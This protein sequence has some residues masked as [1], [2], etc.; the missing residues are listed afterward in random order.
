M[1][2]CKSSVFSSRDS[3]ARSEGLF[4]RPISRHS[5]L[6]SGPSFL[7]SAGIATTAFGLAI[8]I[9]TLAVLYANGAITNPLQ[10]LSAVSYE[11]DNSSS[12][13]ET[14]ASREEQVVVASRPPV[15]AQLPAIPTVAPAQLVPSFTVSNATV[16]IR[17]RINN[18]QIT[19]Y[20]CKRQ[21]FCGSMFNGRRVYEGAAAC[22]WNLSIGT[23]F[24]IA[25]DPSGRTY[26]CEDRGLLA[27]TWVDIFFQDPSDG[28]RWQSA[29]GRTGSIEIIELPN[30]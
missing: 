6:P 19:F 23:R 21:G 11:A 18:V 26:T 1:R 20:D 4:L 3:I 7:A 8:V 24:R 9:S 12:F 15:G 25:G 16:T 10:E 14:I 22:S 27:N 30:R 5:R 29:V 17:G 2:R 28:W 13:F